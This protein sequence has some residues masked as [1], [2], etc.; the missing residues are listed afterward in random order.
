MTKSEIFTN[1]WIAARTAALRFGGKAREYFAAALRD[2]Y[3]A[4]TAQ[5]VS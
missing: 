5:L 1:A 4:L 3:A 2:I